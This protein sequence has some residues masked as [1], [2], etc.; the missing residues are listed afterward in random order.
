MEFYSVALFVFMRLEEESVK[1]TAYSV[2]QLKSTLIDLMEHGKEICVRFRLMGEMWQINFGRVVSVIENRI[3]VND[4]VKN[5]LIAIE[6]SHVMQ[7]EIDHRF[8]GIEPH[9]HYDVVPDNLN[10]IYK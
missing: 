1:K 5:I 2:T 9:F 10:I 8:K 7:F 6:L 3:L 4:E